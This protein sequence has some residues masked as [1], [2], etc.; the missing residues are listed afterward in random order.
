[1]S[2][3]QRKSMTLEEFLA[4]EEQQVERFE[5]VD[6]G[7]SMMAGGTDAHDEVRLAIASTMRAKLAGKPCR[8]RLDLKLV[9]PNGR[10][11]YPDVAVV[12]GPRDPKA[13]R[14][15]DPVVIVEVLSPA[16]RATDYT[17]KP[18]DYGSVPTV[19]VYLLVDPDEPRVD[20]LRR[21]DG[22]LTPLPQLEGLDAI[23]A[24]PELGIDLSLAEIYGD[25]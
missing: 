2:K 6:G 11:R 18:V 25:G 20:V 15:R 3:A 7:L 14:L 5:Y 1:M 17:V 21:V 8:A 22:V 24:L 23:I 4:W 13:T 16:T 12:C 19:A 10:S 9:C